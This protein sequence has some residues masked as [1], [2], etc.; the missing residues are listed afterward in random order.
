LNN[1]LY[2]FFLN[3]LTRDIDIAILTACPSVCLLPARRTDRQF[4]LQNIYIL[5]VVLT[6]R[7]LYSL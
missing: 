1:F 4:S 5:I 6:Q 2:N 3:I 7:G